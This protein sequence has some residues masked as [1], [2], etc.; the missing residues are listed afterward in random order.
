MPITTTPDKEAIRKKEELREGWDQ[1]REKAKVQ[2]EWANLANELESLLE[3]KFA[4]QAGEL[5]AMMTALYNK[6]MQE[7]IVQLK[8]II[9]KERERD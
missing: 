4:R 1:L 5:E 9:S 7:I 2:A 3:R 6:N 8:T